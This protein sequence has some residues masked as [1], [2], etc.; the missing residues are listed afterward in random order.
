[1]HFFI[2]KTNKFFS[3]IIQIITGAPTTTHYLGNAQSFSLVPNISASGIMSVYSYFEST[4]AASTWSQSGNVFTYTGG[5]ATFF[6]NISE[7]HG[8]SSG[9]PD[10]EIQ[11]RKN[12][13]AVA[14]QLCQNTNQQS[15]S[16]GAI[17]SMTTNDTLDGYY[18]IIT[19]GTYDLTYAPVISI[20]KL[21]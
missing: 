17:I 7:S 14:T 2:A 12:S 9:G 1:M 13:V 10:I 21:A 15:Q 3:T 8:I 19:A 4:D 6:V 18:N 20:I 16:I 11:I 5:T